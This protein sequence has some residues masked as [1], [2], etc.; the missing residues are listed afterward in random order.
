LFRLTLSLKPQRP[1]PLKLQQVRVQPV[2]LQ[3]GQGRLQRRV[4]Q[5]QVLQS[6]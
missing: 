4:L 3:R 5:G 6:V 2:P 1:P